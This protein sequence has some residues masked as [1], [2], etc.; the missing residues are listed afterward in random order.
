MT[1]KILSLFL[2]FDLL[3]F[4]V[5]SQLLDKTSSNSR[6]S[7]QIPELSFGKYY[8]EYT[9]TYNGIILLVNT[10][11][12]VDVY[13]YNESA[14]KWQKI[15]VIFYQNIVGYKAEIN[16]KLCLN[17]IKIVDKRNKEIVFYKDVKNSE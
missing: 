6:D 15:D 9:K 12:I 3:S 5:F 4:S 10:K 14:K 1:T 11:P 8:F 17:K 7:V 16:N 13:C 2:I